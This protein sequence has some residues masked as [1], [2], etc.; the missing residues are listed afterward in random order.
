MIGLV[1][2]GVEVAVEYNKPL[3]VVFTVP[4]VVKLERVVIFWVVFTLYVPLVP[5][6]CAPAVPLKVSP[7]P[8][9]I[10]EVATLPSKAG[11]ALFEVQ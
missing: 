10:E 11:V 8:A 5:P 2:V 3:A 4:A 7:V 6:T 9:P 1:T